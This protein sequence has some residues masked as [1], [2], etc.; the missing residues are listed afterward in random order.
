MRK[1]SR[2]PYPEFQELH[3]HGRGAH[4]LVCSWAV[5]SV[6]LPK[7]PQQ[8][9]DTYCCCTETCQDC[10]AASLRSTL[11]LRSGFSCCL[12]RLHLTSECLGLG[13][14]SASSPASLRI[15]FLDPADDGSGTGVAVN[16]MG[17]LEG[18]LVPAC[19]LTQPWLL[20]IF[21]NW[22]SWLKILYLSVSHTLSLPFKW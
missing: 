17:D 19:G 14:A 8:G 9:S 18:L 22:T 11:K 3:P 7:A 16:S 2:M 13:L 6:C 15:M 12:G 4:L 5:R 1:S 21:K 20:L 10:L